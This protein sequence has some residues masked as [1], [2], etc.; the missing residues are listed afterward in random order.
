MTNLLSIRGVSVG[1]GSALAVREVDLDIFR[2]EIIALLG[3]SGCGKTTLLRAVAGFEPLREGSIELAGN[4]VSSERNLVPPE[5]RHI[6]MVFQQGALFP[7]MTVRRNV[8]FGLSGNGDKERTSA[9]L[10]L[11][12]LTDLAA[13]YPDELSGGQQQLVALARAL[14]PR[15]EVVLLD[16]PFAGLD[17]GLREHIRDRVGEI[18]R[19]AGAT[20]LLVTH[21]QQEALGFADRV[22]VMR[23][24]RILQTDTPQG[25]YERPA[26]ID[27][28][29]FIA[30]GR[31]VPAIVK[32][33][34]LICPLGTRP[35]SAGDS[36]G[37]LLVRPDDCALVE[38]TENHGADACLVRTR[39][40][41]PDLLHE[42]E[43]TD[44][45]R[46]QVRTISRGTTPRPGPVRIRLRSG[47]FRW[48]PGESSD[49]IQVR[50]EG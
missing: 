48:F 18:L 42:I 44:G 37:F 39:Y 27:V 47:E 11:A 49:G 1:Y 34:Q 8:S 9:A 32:D 28:A 33:G 36:E 20:A 23:A 35:S 6:G 38:G 50:L 16:E 17:A 12:G 3:P 24:G 13:R 45:T 19:R 22:A 10:E 29:R 26:S 46:V 30:N 40:R 4:C 25:I 43:C 14:A 15:P 2:G 41:G 7:H 5:R 21:D 31:L